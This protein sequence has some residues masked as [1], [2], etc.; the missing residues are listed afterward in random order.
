MEFSTF[1][2]TTAQ[3]ETAILAGATHLILEDPAISVRSFST[4][5]G[6]IERLATLVNH[7]RYLSPEIPLSLNV[8]MLAHMTDLDV[9]RGYIHAAKECKIPRIR[10]Q[11]PGLS[12]LVREIYPD[13]ICHLATETGNA[14]LP[15][16][17]AHTAFFK[18]QCF[19]LDTAF[20]DMKNAI[21]T[22]PGEFEI[23]VQGPILIQY[24]QRRFL[25]GFSDD[26][27]E[28]GAVFAARDTDYPGR[29]YRFYD[30][31][32][33]HFMYLYFDRCLMSCLTELRELNAHSWLIDARGESLDYLKTALFA[34]NIA[35]QNPE[36]DLKDAI[37]TL[38]TASQRPQRPGF[39]RANLTDQERG[40]TKVDDASH[41][42]TVI[43]VIK[44]QSFTVMVTQDFPTTGSLLAITPEGK[45]IYL[46]TREIRDL[47]GQAVTLAQTGQ[48]LR[49]FWQ[50]GICS[51]TVIVVDEPETQGLP[52]KGEQ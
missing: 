15:S 7:A 51:N 23:M 18:R 17:E 37:E 30:N 11:D 33:G 19:A 14:N 2:V 9:I 12:L 26:I 48:L 32:H 38:K 28:H 47:S 34:Y 13:A 36:A 52:A 44:E 43:D 24:S 5:T 31:P 49:F 3:I 8:D 35:Y 20:P 50:K 21:E 16:M 10:V 25:K 39:F 4:D 42:A 27:P 1:C 29:L 41:R 40:T 6:S 45:K 46:K 22:L